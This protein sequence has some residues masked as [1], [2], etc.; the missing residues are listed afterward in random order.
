M[1]QVYQLSAN[2]FSNN[3]LYKRYAVI[4]L[5]NILHM[6]INLKKAGATQFK[7]FEP[8]KS[9]TSSTEIENHKAASYLNN[10]TIY[11]QEFRFDSASHLA[12]KR[13]V[14]FLLE[15][16]LWIKNFPENYKMCMSYSQF[17]DHEQLKMFNELE[18]SIKPAKIIHL[19]SF[20]KLPSLVQKAFCA[21][22][23]CVSVQALTSISFNQTKNDEIVSV[24]NKML[25]L[26]SL[27]AEKLK[28]YFN[29]LYGEPVFNDEFINKNFTHVIN[30]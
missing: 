24:G 18:F 14:R 5:S 21:F 7:T 6:K 20:T 17:N 28:D 27:G 3:P 2:N 16:K 25:K 23:N 10:F 8:V 30:Q 13:T 11:L 22:I 12:C 26:E 9:F 15:K 29:S 1:I 4:G 19:F